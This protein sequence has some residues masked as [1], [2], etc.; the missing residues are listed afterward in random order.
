MFKSGSVSRRVNGGDQ[1]SSSS[2]VA[3]LSNFLTREIIA[4]RK[5]ALKPFKSKFLGFYCCHSASLHGNAVWF[6][7]NL[8]KLDFWCA[9]STVSRH[10]LTAVCFIIQSCKYGVEDKDCCS[11]VFQRPKATFRITRKPDIIKPGSD[12]IW[13][14]ILQI[15]QHHL[16]VMGLR[17]QF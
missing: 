15:P 9:L 1:M 5:K 12:A 13:S 2:L 4:K 14:C 3:R 7:D 6:L 16:I 11:I 8:W 10:F 17:L